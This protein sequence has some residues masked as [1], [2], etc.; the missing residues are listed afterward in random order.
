MQRLDRIADLVG[1][2]RRWL[3]TQTQTPIGDERRAVADLGW[4]VE[5]IREGG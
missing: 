4:A 1:A 2:N 5:R 3:I